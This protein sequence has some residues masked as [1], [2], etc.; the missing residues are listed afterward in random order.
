[1]R[2]LRPE[3]IRLLVWGVVLLTLYAGGWFVFWKGDHQNELP[4]FFDGEETI[5]GFHRK[6]I[7]TLAIPPDTWSTWVRAPE[8]G[9][10]WQMLPYG[11]R[12]KSK[13]D[14]VYEGGGGEMLYGTARKLPYKVVAVRVWNG[15]WH[16]VTGEFFTSVENED[17]PRSNSDIADGREK[18]LIRKITVRPGE[19]SEWDVL[20]AG[21]VGLE[22]DMNVYAKEHMA[23]E[24]A[25]PNHETRTIPATE[26]VFE[27]RAGGIRVLNQNGSPVE[28][29]LYTW[30][31]L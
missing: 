26:Q 8:R 21:C 4:P 23:V 13:Y 11:S 28:V 2:R 7:A 1:M 20:P 3:A 5:S 6:K 9:I 24:L 30:R 14:V 15:N 16:D 19:W 10:A 18:A 22:A 25:F 29:T 31:R 27:E 17:P 12:W